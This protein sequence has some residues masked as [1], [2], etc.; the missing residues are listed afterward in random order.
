M[1]EGEE[2]AKSGLSPLASCVQAE[3]FYRA[4]THFA[5]AAAAAEAQS[6]LFF[7]V[8]QLHTS[9]RGERREK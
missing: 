4:N 5:A 8:L 7:Q 1:E 6:T 2:R 9:G 3:S